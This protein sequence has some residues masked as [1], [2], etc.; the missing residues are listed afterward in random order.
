MKANGVN[1]ARHRCGASGGVTTPRHR[2]LEMSVAKIA[3]EIIEKSA[4]NRKWQ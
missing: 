4:K 3:S 1:V 2:R